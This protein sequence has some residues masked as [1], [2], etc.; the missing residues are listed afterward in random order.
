MPTTIGEL[1]KQVGFKGS[2]QHRMAEP[3]SVRTLPVIDNSSPVASNIRTSVDCYVSGQYVQRNGHVIEVMQRYSIFVAYH[4]ET[5]L[6]TMN[7][8]RDRIIMDFEEKYG[9]TF[10]V[11]NVHVPQLPVP[12]SESIRGIGKGSVGD[13]SFYEGSD[14]FR[15]MTSYEKMRHEIGTQREMAR[16]NIG[17]IRQRYG[18]KR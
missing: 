7:Q 17:S 8:V 13:L 10:N 3:S 1:A 12:K 16:T 2:M 9:T 18:Y 15:Q 11:S 5:Q 4:K 14:L 6:A